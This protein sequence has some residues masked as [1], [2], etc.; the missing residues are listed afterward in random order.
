MNSKFSDIA[1]RVAINR[2]EN[3]IELTKSNIEAEKELIELDGRKQ[4]FAIRKNWS[5]WIIASISL[6]ILF[7]VALV[8]MT[9]LGWLNFHDYDRMITAIFIEDFLQI[10]GMG[11]VVVKFLFPKQL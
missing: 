9:G 7:H 1:S 8:F 5:S 10:V 3:E 6:I 11:Y 2:E 4:F